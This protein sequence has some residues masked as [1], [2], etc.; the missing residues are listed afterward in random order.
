M[1]GRRLRSVWMEVVPGLVEE[2]MQDYFPDD[3][4]RRRFARQG[5]EDMVNEGYHLESMMFDF[6]LRR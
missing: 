6:V 5:Q 3:V 2:Y 4:T 1:D